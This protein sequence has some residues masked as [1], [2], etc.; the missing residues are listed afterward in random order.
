MDKLLKEKKTLEKQICKLQNKL[1]KIN[2]NY[3]EE[4]EKPMPLNYN[5]ITQKNLEKEKCIIYTKKLI[6]KLKK[7]KHIKIK[8]EVEEE[9]EIPYLEYA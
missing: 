9:I 2:K 5:T 6:K 4:F 3:L 7:R 1:E 8:K